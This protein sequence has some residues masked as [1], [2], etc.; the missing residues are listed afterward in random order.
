MPRRALSDHR[1]WLLAAIAAAIGY[2]VLED[3][4]IGGIFIILLKGAGPIMLGAYALSRHPGSD[5]KLIAAVMVVSGLADMALE[6]WF[7]IGAAIFMIAH[8]IAIVLYLRNR[9]EGPPASQLA[10]S[11]VFMLIVPLIGWSLTRSPGVAVY[12]AVLGAMAAAGW[13]SRFPRY[14][15]GVGVALFVVSDLLI[16]TR[17]GGQLDESITNWLVWPLY[18]SGQFLIATGVIQTLRRGNSATRT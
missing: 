8:A 10:L 12:S 17:M 5:A 18:F 1:P 6:L 16:F 4:R 14:R 13:S 2:F 11:A 7:D 9:R 3:A 15:V